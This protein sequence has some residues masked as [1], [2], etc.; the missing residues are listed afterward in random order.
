VDRV[1]GQA[2]DVRE[3]LV[4]VDLV[5]G[6]VLEDDQPGVHFREA[7]LDVVLIHPHHTERVLESGLEH[8]I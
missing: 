2:F 5:F 8:L 6:P 7:D 4:E 1:V 3:A